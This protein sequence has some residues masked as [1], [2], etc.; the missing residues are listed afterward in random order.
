MDEEEGTSME[1]ESP[2][3]V[4]RLCSREERRRASAAVCSGGSVEEEGEDAYDS[5]M[6]SLVSSGT[7][8]RRLKERGNEARR[9]RSGIRAQSKEIRACEREASIN[10]RSAI[11]SE[12]CT[13]RNPKGERPKKKMWKK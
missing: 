4:S 10:I 12:V 5:Y 6:L 7:K 13:R 11:K 8:E 1:D 3:R 9:V 2:R